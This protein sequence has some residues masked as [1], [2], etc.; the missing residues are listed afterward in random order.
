[1]QI[2]FSWSRNK[3]V[4]SW[5]NFYTF[6]NVKTLKKLN[7]YCIVRETKVTISPHFGY[8]NSSFVLSLFLNL[9]W[10]LQ[11]SDCLVI[12]YNYLLYNYI[13]KKITLSYALLLRNIRHTLSLMLIGNDLKKLMKTDWL[14]CQIMVKY[15]WVKGRENGIFFLS[16]WEKFEARKEC[17]KSALCSSLEF[18]S[19]EIPRTFKCT[20]FLCLF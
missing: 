2:V 10:S 5:W 12:L 13:S 4:W 16:I 9:K 6:A 15:I 18:R 7:F 17:S 19:E 14:I 3:C 11:I 1:M 8:Y 20:H